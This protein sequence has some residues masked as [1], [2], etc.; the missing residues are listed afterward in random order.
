MYLYILKEKYFEHVPVIEIEIDGLKRNDL[1][2][3]S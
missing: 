3:K 1:I 2:F